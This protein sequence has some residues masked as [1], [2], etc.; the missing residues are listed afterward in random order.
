MELYFR[1]ETR[2]FYVYVDARKFS[3]VYVPKEVAN[4]PRPTIH[5][6]V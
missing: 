4:S 5:I 2:N 3:K 1:Y 6:P